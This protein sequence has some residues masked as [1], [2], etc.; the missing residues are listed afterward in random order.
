MTSR[1][2]I[3]LSSLPLI[4]LHDLHTTW[5]RCYD[6]LQQALG[7]V[8]PLAMLRIIKEYERTF[9]GKLLSQWIVQ[10]QQTVQTHLTEIEVF[11]DLIVCE[12]YARDGPNTLESETTTKEIYDLKGVHKRSI[13]SSGITWMLFEE[14]EDVYCL[15]SATGDGPRK[16]T[17]DTPPRIPLVWNEAR[18]RVNQVLTS[19]DRG[20]LGLQK[21]H[22]DNDLFEESKTNFGSVE[23]QTQHEVADLF[24]N[25]STRIDAIADLVF[26][27]TAHLDLFLIDWDTP[28]NTAQLRRLGVGPM[29]N[30]EGCRWC[31]DPRSFC[32]ANGSL[33][34]RW[35]T[36]D[37][38]TQISVFV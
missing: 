13:E 27:E 24:V 11:G 7:R 8:L 6:L 9:Q 33:I 26:L 38:N 16:W 36:P 37:G 19:E 18:N 30:M 12:F 25:R 3:Q 31:G 17:P 4:T 2:G 1:D 35:K 15:T 32:S 20:K 23:Q 21:D 14:E 5:N 10:A 34:L 22:W 29:M 28:T